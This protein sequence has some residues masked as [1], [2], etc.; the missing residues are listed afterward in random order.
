MGQ[1]II[2]KIGIQ[3]LNGFI[4]KEYY[5]YEWLSLIYIDVDI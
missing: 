1:H 5:A 3:S 2:D 4:Y